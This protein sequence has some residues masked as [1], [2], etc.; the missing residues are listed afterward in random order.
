MTSL[1]NAPRASH[2]GRKL[3]AAFAG[4][5]ALSASTGAMA[6]CTGTGVFAG[7]GLSPILPFAAGGAVNSLVSAINTANTAFLTQSTAFVSA[8]GNPQPNQE[9]GG[10]W[11]RGIGGE[12]TT[13]ATSTTSNV[14]L[15]GVGV[16]G[17]VDC[18]SE[19]KLKFAGAQ[20][21]ADT[22]I[23][24][25][26]GWNLHVGSTVG[27][28]GAKANDVSS[29]GP[30]NPLGGTFSDTLQVP[31]AGVYA[32]VTK[33]GFFMDGQVR[34]EFYQNSVNDPIVAGIFSQKLDARGLSFTGN[35]GFNAPLQNNWFIEPSAGIVV[36]KVKVDP[37][38]VT[39]SLALPASFTPGI[40]FPGQ[41]Q[42][43]DIRSTLG[44]LSL[45]GGTTIASGNMIWQPF[46]IASV[47]HEFEQSVTSTFDSGPATLQAFGP[48]L[49]GVA[50]AG[51]ISTSNIGTYGQFGVGIAG[52]IVNT[53]FLGYLR[54]DY[55][56]GENIEGYSL[57]GGIRYQFSPEPLVAAPRMYTKGGP[58][59]KAPV[60]VQVAYDW[61]GFFVGGSFG[62]L[63][64]RTKWD[65]PAFGTNTDPRFAGAL[66]GGQIGY[67]RQF[68]K[69]VVGIEGAAYGSNASGARACP[70][71]VFFTCETDVAW[72][73]TATA[74]LGYAFWNRSL[75]YVRGGGAFGDLGV[76]TR[77][78]T[79]NVGSPVLGLAANCAE[80]STQNRVG[81]T[82]G[83][84][85]EFA[86][87][88]NWT[89]RTETN[90]FDM[91]RERYNF[92][93]SNLDADVH[94][95]GFI[96]TVGLN[97]RFAPALV[98]AKY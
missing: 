73:G 50:P 5:M 35:I 55:R 53:G 86:L 21:G 98:T 8:P 69:W 97:Y 46:A 1:F 64:G 95:T 40:T 63:N 74:K 38:N 62:A 19:T 57:N 30:L 66:Y 10:V 90:Y 26:N 24:N 32:A 33:G 14:T 17:T 22:S 18:A 91:G 9:G 68:G 88:R 47:Y 49:A 84:G 39:G 31:F 25:Y 15:G 96:S 37:L 85:S 89:V 54:G 52:Q 7:A 48:V 4:V 76:T 60:L 65:F 72:I 87:S 71:G 94:Q 59:V 43:N 81:W 75:V 44:R 82:V 61:T 36:S 41:L 56:T 80:S 70:N 67:D 13:K 45:R 77:C 93:P 92:Q 12:I 34:T 16:P 28:I 6:S 11:A 3:L 2:S 78:N 83:I 20:V 29:A 51:T 58:I 23:L 27:Y 42:I 79:G